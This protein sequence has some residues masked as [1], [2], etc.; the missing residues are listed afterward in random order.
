MGQ[1]Q[2]SSGLQ[3]QTEVLI[4]LRQSLKTLLPALER[5]L[6]LHYSILKETIWNADQP[7]VTSGHHLLTPRYLHSQDVLQ[8]GQTDP[9]VLLAVQGGLT[10]TN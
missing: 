4:S 7:A 8:L 6:D 9:L 5:T 3:L 2:L 1:S 10:L